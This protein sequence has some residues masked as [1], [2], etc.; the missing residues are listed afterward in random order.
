MEVAMGS[1]KPAS[2]ACSTERRSRQILRTRSPAARSAGDDDDQV[3]AEL[4]GEGFMAR[5]MRREV[6][7]VR[8]ESLLE[9]LGTIDFTRIDWWSPEG[10]GSRTR[11]MD[12]AWVTVP[13]IPF[14][15]VSTRE[16]RGQGGDRERPDC[17]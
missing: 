1:A 11:P 2:T 17:D 4:A 12:I 9:D 13:G 7:M 3:E 10:S 5:D 15:P 16:Y 6:P 8:P 14:Q